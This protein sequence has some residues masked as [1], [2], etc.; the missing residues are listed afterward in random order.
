MKCVDAA[1]RSPLHVEDPDADRQAARLNHV[2]HEA[3][4]R[5]NVIARDLADHGRS[6]T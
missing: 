6:S 3:W 2:I 4:K 5:G 1:G